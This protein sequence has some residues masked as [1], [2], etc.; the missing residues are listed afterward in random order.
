[1]VSERRRNPCE[2]QREREA[3]NNA[4]KDQSIIPNAHLLLLLLFSLILVPF[5]TDIKD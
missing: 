3:T 5:K 4:E 2:L 1:M